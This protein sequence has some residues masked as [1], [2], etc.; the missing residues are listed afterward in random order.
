MK[1]VKIPFEDAY[2]YDRTSFKYNTYSPA[3]HL[4]Y[5]SDNGL[6]LGASVNFIQQNYNKPD[7][8]SMH[9]FNIRVSTLGNLQLGYEGTIRHVL[10]EWDLTLAARGSDAKRFNYFFW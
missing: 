1:E 8:S 7:F 3:G 9:E 2:R 10:G 5:T 6:R 4:Y